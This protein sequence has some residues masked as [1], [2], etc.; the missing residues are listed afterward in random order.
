[1]EIIEILRQFHDLGSDDR[2][3]SLVFFPFFSPSSF[4]ALSF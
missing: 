1:M 2:L 4:K 3:Y